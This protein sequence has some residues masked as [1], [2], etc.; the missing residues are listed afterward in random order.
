MANN[1]TDEQLLRFKQAGFSAE[2]ISLFMHNPAYAPTEDELASLLVTNS[3]SEAVELLPENLDGLF[4]HVELTYGV[5]FEEG[6]KDDELVN[7]IKLLAKQNP[8]LAKQIAALYSITEYA[9][10]ND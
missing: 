10:L 8:E 1:F 2:E 6:L 3:L 4:E 7:R 9:G 5:L